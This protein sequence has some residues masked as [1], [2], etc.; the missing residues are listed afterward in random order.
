MKRK[1]PVFFVLLII[2]VLGMVQ[3]G[4][5]AGDLAPQEPTLDTHCAFCKMEVYP[6]THGMGKYT[7]QMVPPDG[8]HLFFDDIGCM[9][10]DKRNLTSEPQ[11]M[12][13]RDHGT[14][15]WME[16]DKASVVSADIQT[17]MHYGFAFFKNKET[18]DKF[19]ESNK[20]L[21]A[22]MVDWKLVDQLAQK[23]LEMKKAGHTQMGQ[24]QV[25]INGEKL[26]FHQAPII[27]EGRVLVP[28]RGVFEK[29]GATVQWDQQTK[30]VKAV[31]GGTTITLKM[32]T[33]V[34][35]VNKK[36]ITLDVPAKIYNSR[37]MV[38]V[39]AI[40]EALGAKVNWDSKTR[41]VMIHA[42]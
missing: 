18:A 23:R 19:V 34:I 8:K 3:I 14:L 7:A 10:N 31:K 26:S 9:L 33:K 37:A 15:E 22:I 36:Q 1:K 28:V 40:S 2:F 27:V 39:R 38:P 5:A 12:W 24:I 32:N 13:V 30:T 16:W 29:L 25:M 20:K 21:E 42:N 11:K 17:P 6:K 35:M 4:A 41:T